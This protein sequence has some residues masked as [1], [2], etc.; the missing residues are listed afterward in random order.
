MNTHMHD[1]L[2]DYNINQLVGAF[3]AWLPVSGQSVIQLVGAV[4]IRVAQHEDRD[5]I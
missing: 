4:S 1:T 3:G 2:K 5:R